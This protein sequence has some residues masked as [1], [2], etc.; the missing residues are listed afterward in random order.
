MRKKRVDVCVCMKV[1]RRWE[2]I[3]KKRKNKN[4]IVLMQRQLRES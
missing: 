3:K 2:V 1:D 4:K